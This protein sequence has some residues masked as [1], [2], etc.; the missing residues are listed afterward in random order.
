MWEQGLGE[1]ERA[2]GVYSKGTLKDGE[3]GSFE[4]ICIVLRHY[5]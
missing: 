4:G 5:A 1:E 3:I 2:V